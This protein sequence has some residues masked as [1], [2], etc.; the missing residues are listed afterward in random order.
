MS[1]RPTASRPKMKHYGIETSSDG[2]LTWEWVEDQLTKARNYWLATTQPDGA[3]HVAPF[4][5]IWQDGVLLFST[6]AESRK[7]RN[8]AANP[9]AAVHLESGDE[10]VMLDGRVLV[11]EDATLLARFGELYVAKYS[12]DPVQDPVPGSIYYVFLP[13]KGLSWQEHDFPKTATRWSFSAPPQEDSS[14]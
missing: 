10:V 1:T 3:P 11:T 5:G 6:H 12:V 8:L 4:W 7:A 9:R 13:D 2:M 14:P